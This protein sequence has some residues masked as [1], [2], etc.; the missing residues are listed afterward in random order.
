MGR[1]SRDG[2]GSEKDDPC[3]WSVPVREPG[4]IERPVTDL[5][6]RWAVG[7]RVDA[8]GMLL[9]RLRRGVA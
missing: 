7:E 5:G 6:A 4:M 9:A 1:C 2:I 3:T 8:L